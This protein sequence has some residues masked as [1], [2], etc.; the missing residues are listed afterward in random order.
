MRRRKRKEKERGE[1]TSILE[2]TRRTNIKYLVLEILLLLSIILHKL[3]DG[4]KAGEDM[5]KQEIKRK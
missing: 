4:K 2:E 3:S 5:R 1:E